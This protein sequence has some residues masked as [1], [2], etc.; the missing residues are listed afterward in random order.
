MMD[1]QMKVNCLVV[2]T[3][4]DYYTKVYEV[5]NRELQ[6]GFNEFKQLMRLV[7]YYIAYKGYELN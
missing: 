6:E 3:I 7:A 5:S 4:S 2:S 1:P